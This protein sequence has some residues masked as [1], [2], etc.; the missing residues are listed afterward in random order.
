VQTAKGRIRNGRARW[1]R[2][3][4]CDVIDFC[5]WTVYRRAKAINGRVRVEY[6]D[7]KSILILRKIAEL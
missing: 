7:S 4:I 2:S 5:S 6:R 3:L 1:W